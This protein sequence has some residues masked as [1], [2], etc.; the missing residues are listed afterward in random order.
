MSVPL[1]IALNI[2]AAAFLALLVAALMLLPKR[3]HP[4][5]HP[6]L[7]V[8]DAPTTRPSERPHEHSVRSR[9]HRQ[10]RGGRT[11]TDS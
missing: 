1:I 6:H 10:G 4:H 8:P 11:V 7:K 2:G 9:R 3:L 5:R